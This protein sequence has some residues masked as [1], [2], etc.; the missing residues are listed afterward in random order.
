MP[1]LPAALL[2]AVSATAQEPVEAVWAEPVVTFE[3]VV[4]SEDDAPL[5]GA[6][7]LVQG[8]AIDE[9]VVAICDAAGRFHVTDLPAGVY[10]ISVSAPAFRTLGAQEEVIEGQVTEARYRLEREGEAMETVV[11]ARRPPREMTRRTLQTREIARM[12]GTAGDALRSVQNMPGVARPMFGSGVVVIRGSAP[13]DT[14]FHLDGVPIPLLYHFGAFRSAIA[15][16]LIERIDFYPGNYSVRYSGV[17][18]GIVDVT[19]RTPRREDWTGY[20]DANVIDAGAFVEGPIGGRAS[21]AAAVRRSYIDATLPA[22]LP[23]HAGFSIVAAPVYWDYQLL[24]D[25]EPTGADRLRFFVYGSD[26]SLAF[27]FGR[28]D[29]RDPAMTGD[30]SMNVGFHR[31][32]ARWIRDLGPRAENLLLVAFGYNELRFLA[33]DTF[34]IT[35]RFFPIRVREEFTFRPSDALRVTL[36]VDSGVE[37]FLARARI[38]DVLEAFESG[39][40]DDMPS[41]GFANMLEVDDSGFGVAPGFYVETELRPAPAVRLIPGVRLDLYDDASAIAVEP[42]FNARWDVLDGTTLKAGVGLYS[43]PPQPQQSS[44]DTGNP[45]LDLQRSYHYGVGVEQRIWRNIDLAV[46]LFFKNVDRLVRPTTDEVLRDGELVA[47]RYDNDGVGRAYG[48]ELLLRYNPD[49]FFFGWIAL[50]VLRSERWEPGE[51]WFR[52]HFD[53]TVNLTALGSFDIGA[54]WSAGFRFRLVSGPLTT[55][56]VGSIYDADA[57]R[58]LPIVGRRNSVRLPLF[59]QLDLRVDKTFDWGAFKLSVYLDVQNVYYNA[60]VEEIAYSYDYTETAYVTG[61]PIIPA[62][63]IK[64]EF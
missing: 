21:I 52:S 32:E 6:V 48:M 60:N 25:W 16:D 57:D 49:D 1:D 26:D 40:H 11:R 8:G 35:Y 19:P 63:G 53:Q 41:I 4:L 45:D 23:D 29:Q 31:G 51:G 18:G 9:P 44:P 28:P 14:A 20:V 17:M 7:V 61:L 27:L 55:P 39:G 43:Q 47:E 36:G 54:G 30:L 2:A 12:P 13:A 46:D 50:T 62:L 33:A 38:P 37:W 22:L 59:H 56:V 5:E 10:R 3:G 58:Y 64:G 34:D 24:W 42:R 15:S